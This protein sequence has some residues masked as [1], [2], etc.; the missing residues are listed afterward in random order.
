MFADFTGILSDARNA[1]QSRMLSIPALQQSIDASASQRLD[2]LLSMEAGAMGV[3][4]NSLMRDL[5]FASLSSPN[6]V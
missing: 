2:A 4:K 6:A 5:F 3:T 1:Y